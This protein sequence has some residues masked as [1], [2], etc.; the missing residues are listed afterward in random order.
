MYFYVKDFVMIVTIKP[1]MDT[2][3]TRFVKISALALMKCRF[4]FYLSER[5]ETLSEFRYWWYDIIKWI[6]W[7]HVTQFAFYGPL[8][9]YL[10][11]SAFYRLFCKIA[12]LWDIDLK[13]SGF[14]FDVN[15]DNPAKFREASMPRSCIS[16]YRD[17]RYFGL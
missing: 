7:S 6:W 8:C 9:I 10:L 17:F 5:L 13:F 11:F 1:K 3:Q 2:T 14:I 16:K 12:D 4:Q 15:I